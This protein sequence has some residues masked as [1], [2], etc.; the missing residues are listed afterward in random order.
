VLAS[1]LKIE[2]EPLAH[3]NKGTHR[4]YAEYYNAEAYALV[5]RRCAAEIAA[6]GYRF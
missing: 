4:P 6:F 1:L 3:R 2:G 5:A